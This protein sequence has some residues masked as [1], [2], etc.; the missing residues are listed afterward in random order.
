MELIEEL[1]STHALQ[2]V[3]QDVKKQQQSAML[4]M[5]KQREEQQHQVR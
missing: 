5:Q 3:E 1:R 4:E 2:E